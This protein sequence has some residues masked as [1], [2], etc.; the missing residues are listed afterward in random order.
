[1]CNKQ[2][3][4]ALLKFLEEPFDEIYAIFTSANISKVLPTIISRCQVYPIVS[5][6]A[7]KLS[8]LSNFNLTSQEKNIIIDIYKDLDNLKYDIENTNL[9]ELIIFSLEMIKAKNDVTLYK[10]TFEIF[11]K[12]SYYEIELIVKILLFLTKTEGLVD[13]LDTIK[14]NP[15]KPLL[16]D[17]II[18]LIKH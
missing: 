12:K 17:K 8:L 4:N 7:E 14:F 16:F 10:K 11:R 1:L 9:H 5:S 15:V 3:T 6:K 13:I 2:T 18:Q